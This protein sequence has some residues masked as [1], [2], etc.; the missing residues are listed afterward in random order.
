[1]QRLKVEVLIPKFYN[2]GRRIEG[3]KYRETYQEVFSQFGGCT[4]DNSPLLGRWI[5]PNTHQEYNE[6]N[7]AFWVICN[8]TYD[9]LYFLDNLKN[10]LKTRFDQKEIMIYSIKIDLL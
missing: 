9:S 4:I 8:D 1:V 5:D 6:K 3:I 2:D 10:K 7:I